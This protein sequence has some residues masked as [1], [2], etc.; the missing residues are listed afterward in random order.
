MKCYLL[1]DF[2]CLRFSY[3]V[4]RLDPLGGSIL[5]GVRLEKL[6]NH[7]LVEIHVVPKQ[8]LDLVLRI[9]ELEQT[10]QELF[11]ERS[12]LLY[13]DR[14]HDIWKMVILYRRMEWVSNTCGVHVYEY[15]AKVRPLSFYV[16]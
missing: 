12:G 10:R 3:K 6:I 13:E 2:S 11:E 7:F 5:P 14:H 8:Q 16:R 4:T 1:G 15:D 9:V